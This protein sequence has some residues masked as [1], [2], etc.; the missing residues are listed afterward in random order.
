MKPGYKTTEFWLSS[1][2]V[3]LSALFASGILGDGGMDLTIA[4]LVATILGA[5][6]YSVSRAVVKGK[7]E[8][9]S[10]VVASAPPKKK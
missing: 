9:A 4:S 1:I 5:M 3:L 8:I 6:G 7:A 2:A 10:A